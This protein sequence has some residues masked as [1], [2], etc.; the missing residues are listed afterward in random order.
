MSK[1][2]HVKTAV[3]TTLGAVGGAV[4]STFIANWMNSYVFW[5]NLII[6]PVYTIFVFF[7]V[8]CFVKHL[9]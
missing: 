5:V 1:K 6:I 4:I 2:K 9:D 8:Y 7:V 3:Y